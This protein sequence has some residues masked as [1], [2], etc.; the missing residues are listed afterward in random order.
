MKGLEELIPDL[1]DGPP[2]IVTS[3]SEGERPS[4]SDA[5]ENN[6]SSDECFDHSLEEIPPSPKPLEATPRPKRRKERSRP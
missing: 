4:N 1:S 5:E 2:G 3:S 6:T